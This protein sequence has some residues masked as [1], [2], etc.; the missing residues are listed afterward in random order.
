MERTVAATEPTCPK[1]MVSGPGGAGLF[2]EALAAVGSAVVG[3]A[4]ATSAVAHAE[5][6][7]L[8]ARLANARM[9][10][11]PYT[12]ATATFHAE[13]MEVTHPHAPGKA[14]SR[15]LMIAATAYE[16]GASLATLNPGD[17]R[18]VEHLVPIVVPP[19]RSA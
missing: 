3:V 12:D 7:S 11:L 19:R 18:H 16:L 9:Q 8:L 1:S 14:R 6:R 2:A 17:F 10:W 4:V 5:R 15:D 13:L